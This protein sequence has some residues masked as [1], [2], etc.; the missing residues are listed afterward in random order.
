MCGVVMVIDLHLGD[1]STSD[2][3]AIFGFNGN[4][5]NFAGGSGDDL[6]VGGYGFDFIDLSAGGID[7][8]VYRINSSDT[9]GLVK[10]EDGFD[11][12]IEFTPGEDKLVIL[13]VNG[14]LTTL[15]GFFDSLTKDYF[16]LGLQKDTNDDGDLSSSELDAGCKSFFE[17]ISGD[18]YSRRPGLYCL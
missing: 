4:S 5:D 6:F 18:A 16:R 17:Y 7:T 2:N 10:A 12:V 14:S 1:E 8:V 9:D 13:D 3:Q 15:A 11:A